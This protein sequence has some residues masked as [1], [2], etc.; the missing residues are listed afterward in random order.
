M[1]KRIII[2]ISLILISLSVL[3]S[4]HI[5][6][7][8]KYYY[9]KNSLTPP[10]LAKISVERYITS[11]KIV[12]LKAKL[13]GV[14]AEKAGAFVSIHKQGNL[15]GCIGTISPIKQ[16]LRE[17]IVSNAISAATKDYRFKVI[18]LGELDNLEYSVDILSP[19]QKVQ[20]VDELNP[21]KYGII[22]TANSGKRA[23]LLPNLPGIDT[24]EKQISITKQK[25][26]INSDEKF[27]IQKF[28]VK[29]YTL[30]N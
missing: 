10:Q 18:N 19:L 11:G 6:E 3:I 7:V 23:V 8:S 27:E 25:A 4:G 21:T 9:I 28:E 5:Q 29:R 15:R 2:Y 12:K 13:T 24:V 1:K 30:Q 17:E 14:Q 22:L 16:D 26:R 20:S